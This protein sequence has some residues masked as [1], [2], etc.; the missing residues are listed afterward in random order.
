MYKMIRTMDTYSETMYGKKF[1]NGSMVMEETY[2]AKSDFDNI[3]QAIEYADKLT[4]ISN[5]KCLY[6][7]GLA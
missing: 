5:G 2:F 4:E 1:I 6:L 7:V 3:N